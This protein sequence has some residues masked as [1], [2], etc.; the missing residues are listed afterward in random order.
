MAENFDNLPSIMN[1]GCG[2]DY[3]INEYYITI[4][5]ILGF[6]GEFKNNLTMPT[7]MRR[8]I[9]NID[10]QKELGWMPKI[11]LK[12]GI[13]LSYNYFKEFVKNEL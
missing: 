8:K 10:K 4:A 6:K 5:N 13:K 1:I 7:G 11:E 9:V 12:E 3:T 2:K